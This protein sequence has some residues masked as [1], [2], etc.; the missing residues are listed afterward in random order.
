MST[1]VHGLLKIYE[2]NQRYTCMM[3][4]KIICEFIT[5]LVFSCSANQKK[6]N[7][8]LQYTL[9]EKRRKKKR[10]VAVSSHLHSK[11]RADKER[12][13]RYNTKGELR[14]AVW[15]WWAVTIPFIQHHP[16]FLGYTSTWTISVCLKYFTQRGTLV[17]RHQH[18]SI[19]SHNKRQRHQT[20]EK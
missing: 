2:R 3:K 1:V 17:G 10:Q 18:N 20:W 9:K 19:A 15:L 8:T 16:Q 6:K 12:R 4:Q 14:K 13:L 11:V 5:K 7:T